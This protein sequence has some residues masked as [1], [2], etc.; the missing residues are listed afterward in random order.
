LGPDADDERRTDW[1]R[2]IPKRANLILLILAVVSLV[3][4]VVGQPRLNPDALVTRNLPDAAAIRSATTFLE[5]RGV[6][7]SGYTTEVS[8]GRSVDLLR[9][10]Q[11]SAGRRALMSAN[12][13]QLQEGAPLHFMRVRFEADEGSSASG[14]YSVWLSSAGRPWQFTRTGFDETSGE[15]IAPAAEVDREALAVVVAGGVDQLDPADDLELYSD[16]TIARM[17][18]FRPRIAME[19]GFTFDSVNAQ[20]AR[21]PAVALSGRNRPV[22]LDASAAV[23]LGRFHLERDGLPGWDFVLDSVW[24]SPGQPNA[25]VRFVG[26]LDHLPGAA[27]VDLSDSAIENETHVVVGPAGALQELTVAF[28]PERDA[29]SRSKEVTAYVIVGALYLLLAGFL[30]VGFFRRLL[31]RAIDVKPAL[32]D[33]FVFALFFVAMVVSTRGILSGE[34][35]IWMWAL[36]IAAVVFIGGTASALVGFVLSGAADSIGRRGWPHNLLAGN[37]LRRGSVLNAHVGNSLLRGLALGAVL[38]GLT[39]VFM[40]AFGD[41]AIAV[42][43]ENFSGSFRFPVVGAFGISGL[44][45]YLECVVLVLTVAALFYSPRKPRYLALSGVVVVLAFA[46]ASLITFESVW[47]MWIASAVVGLIVALAFWKFD[48]LTVFVALS[49]ASFVWYLLESWIVPGSPLWVDM[50]LAGLFL[51]FVTVVGFVGVV[52]GY[53][54][55]GAEDYVPSYIQEL[56]LQERVNRELEIAR[57]VQQSFLPSAMPKMSRLDVAARCIPAEV[58]GGDYYDFVQLDR[59]RLVLVIGDVSGKGIQASF[60]MTLTKGFLRSLCREELSPADV[61]RK[62]NRLFVESAPRGIFISI[63]YGIVDVSRGEFRFA[64]AG[65]NP[66]IVRRV[67]GEAVHLQP[68]GLAIGLDRGVEFDRVIQDAT[69]QISDG[70]TLVFY[71]DGLSEARNPVSDEFGDQRV[72]DTV[73]RLDATSAQQ[74]LDDVYDEVARFVEGARQHDDMTILVAR[75]VRDGQIPLN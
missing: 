47:L 27:T 58:V 60:F 35:T 5:Q 53:H 25:N 40:W 44:W 51:A 8:R 30:F 64:R 2:L 13:D 20:P 4:F 49:S 15:V 65:H 43:E 41:A 12:K 66:V 21:G 63:V 42:E 52:R 28:S 32:I 68:N 14:S 56:R 26:T 6:D 46:R 3:A 16:S 11:E 67:N 71:T 62:M 61:L 19:S 31:A 70:D 39:T 24:T 45:A 22:L 69:V 10:V 38:L 1:R 23:A 59:H 29:A 73:A 37:L 17:L 57:Q 7:V 74:L 75:L 48:L 36:A 9:A 33:G 34:G 55:P 18:R 54:V 50:L 72:I